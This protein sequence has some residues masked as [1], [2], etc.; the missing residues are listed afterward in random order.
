VHS[1]SDFVDGV[2]TSVITPIENGN[3]MFT[4]GTYGRVQLPTTTEEIIKFFQQEPNHQF[5]SKQLVT[6]EQISPFKLYA[7]GCKCIYKHAEKV[8]N[9]LENYVLLGDAVANFNPNFGQGMTQAAAHVM[10]MHKVFIEHITK[11]PFLN[12]DGISKIIQKRVVAISNEYWM[13]STSEDLTRPTTI[14]KKTV[15]TYSIFTILPFY[16]AILAIT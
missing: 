7:S 12:L 11:N 5:F 8:P 13:A 10:E 1:S 4:I 14:G 9:W 16:C 2:K 15:F 6:F 3:Y